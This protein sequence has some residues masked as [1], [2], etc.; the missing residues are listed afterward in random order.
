MSSKTS[1]TVIRDRDLCKP[2]RIQF[3]GA[4][5]G[6]IYRAIPSRQKIVSTLE[7]LSARLSQ[8]GRLLPGDFLYTTDITCDVNISSTNWRCPISSSS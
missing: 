2:P 7:A 1:S 5:G 8:P 6:V 3:P 4:A